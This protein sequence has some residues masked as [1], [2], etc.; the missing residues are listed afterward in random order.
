VKEVGI[1]IEL[2]PTEYAMYWSILFSGQF[3]LLMD[4][5]SAWDGDGSHLLSDQFH[6]EG[7]LTMGINMTEEHQALVDELIEEA[8]A[9]SDPDVTEENYREVQKIVVDEEAM[10][11]PLVYEVEVVAAWDNV[12]EFEI[13]PHIAWGITMRDVY[14]TE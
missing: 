6:S 5:W 14:N 10:G 3:D 12:K 2:V 13:H 7:G 4:F 1:K 11:V 8:L 9:T